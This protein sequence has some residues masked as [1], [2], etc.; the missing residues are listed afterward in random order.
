MIGEV[1]AEPAGE[2]P[3]RAKLVRDSDPVCARTDKL[4]EE[5]VDADGRLRDVLVR[6]PNGSAGSQ[7]APTEPVVV[8]QRECMYTPRVVGVVTGH[9]LVIRN[10]DATYHNI[11]AASG[12]KTVFNLSQPA[13]APE[14]TRDNLGKAGEVI[15]LHC[16][17]HGW[18]QAFA[19]VNDHP[20]FAVT[21]EDGAFT[22]AG[23][24]AGTYQLEAWHPT[25]GQQTVEVTVKAGKTASA[26]FRFPG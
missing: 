7:P 17:V 26:T 11:R 12:K 4:G 14:I 9:Q 23:V 8:T 24:P 1:I 19:V 15:A 2:P 22:L 13:S 5:V 21:G 16:D 20:H 25:L 10:A 3:A 6:L 18:M